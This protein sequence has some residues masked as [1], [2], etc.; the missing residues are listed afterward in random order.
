VSKKA[1]A[2]VLVISALVPVIPIVLWFSN[3]KK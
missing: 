3:R 2:T 1:W